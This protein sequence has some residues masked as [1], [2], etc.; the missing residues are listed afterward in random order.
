MAPSNFGY[1]LREAGHHFRRNLSTALGAVVTIFLS[2]FIIGVFVLGSSIIDNMVGSVEDKVTIQAFISDDASQDKVDALQSSIQGWDNVESVT[3]KSK[4]E[5]LEEY[6][7]TMSNKNAAAAVEALD[8]QNPVPASLVINLDDPQQVSATADRLIADP[9]F[10]EVCD[11]TDDPAA[12]VQYGQETVERLFSVANYIRVIAVVLVVMLTFVAFVFINNTIRLAISA[13]RREI[14]IMRLV[15]A[16][17]GF[18]RGPFLM[19]GALEA[20]IGALLSIGALQL[21]ISVLLPRLENSLQFLVISVDPAV[22]GFTYGTLV[23]VGLLIGLFGSA[24]A[25]GRYLKV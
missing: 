13:R 18:I 10:A 11:D 24:I 20:L 21:I 15:G 1:S 17:N 2:L 14:A 6:R 22:V 16:S 12:S 4:D 3:Y 9:S 8:G 23:L 19:E 25:M 5:A 7:T